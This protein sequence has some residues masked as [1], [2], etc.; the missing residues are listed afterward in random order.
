ML[1]LRT[2]LSAL[3]MSMT[4][5]AQVPDNL[6]VEGVPAH[7]AELLQDVGRYLEFRT[8]SFASWHPVRREMLVGTRFADTLQLHVVAQPGGAR[9]QMTFSAEPVAGGVFEPVQG[10]F[11][12]F[13]QDSGGGEF[14][15]LKRLDL[16]DGRITLLTDGRSRNSNPHFSRDGRWLYFNSTRRN[17][18]D[19]DLWRMNPLRADSAELLLEVTG[20][21]WGVLDVDADGSRVLMQS[22]RSIND[23]DLHV[24]DT[25]TGKIRQVSPAGGNGV[26]HGAARFARDGASVFCTTDRDSEFQRLARIDLASGAVTVLTPDLKWDVESFEP[27]PDGRQLAFSTN[28]DGI[29]RLHLLNL[30]SLKLKPVAGLPAGVLGGLEWHENGRDLGFSLAHAQSPTDAY[31]LEL[32]SGRITRWTESETGGLN[33]SDFRPP[34]LIR[35]KSFDTLSVSAFV[36]RPDPAKFPG[37]RPVLVLI[38]GGPESQARPGFQA[39]YNYLLNELGIAMVI[40]NVRGSAGYGKTFLTLD[41]GF[42]REDSV[43]DIGAILDWVAKDA[44]LDASRIAVMGGSY[45]GYMT[46]ASLVHYS[47]R[48]KCGVDV[49]GISNFVTFLTNTQDY[50]RDLRRVEYGDERDPKMRE[51]LERISPLNNVARMRV[52]LFVVQGK[53]DPRVPLTE[54]EQMVAALRKQGGTCWYLMAR[55]EGHGFAKK[56]NADFQFV[57]T[58]LFLKEHLLR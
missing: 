18:R 9:R 50:R 39:R 52:P 36:H 7:P 25:I 8:A 5:S 12:V 30:K 35:T 10:R 34:E 23:S 11:I 22:R 58:I 48:L 46:L 26:S 54:A 31:S 27:S 21:G 37:R 42:K 56:R 57:S 51:H 40:P 20:G 3:L 17:G 28:E 47:D 14:Y 33:P 4:L 2:A 32:K 16:A 53:N 45:G 44:G 49:V 13:S 41:D 38:H 15:Q 43:K 55:D 6:V 24:V 1:R 19:T 29:S